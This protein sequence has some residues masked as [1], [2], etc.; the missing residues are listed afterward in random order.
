MTIDPVVHNSMPI[1]AVEQEA[2]WEYV[3]CLVASCAIVVERSRGSAH[4][5]YGDSIYPLDYGYLRGS[6]SSDMAELDAWL[7]SLPRASVQGVLCC[8]DLA[9]RDAEFK[10]LIGCSRSEIESALEFCSRATMRS[11]LVLRPQPT[12]EE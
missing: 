3:D 10:L 2:F 5:R 1:K 11:L 4:P 6:R 12:L 7:G 8:V 9:K